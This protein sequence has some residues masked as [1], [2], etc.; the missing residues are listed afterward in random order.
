MNCHGKHSSI[1]RSCPKRKQKV[2]DHLETKQQEAKQEQQQ[3]SST[4][5]NN[6]LTD[7]NFPSLKRENNPSNQQIS[8]EPLQGFW[9][10]NTINQQQHNHNTQHQPNNQ[11]SHEWEIKLSIAGRYDIKRRPGNIP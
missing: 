10:N 4:V 2:D 3:Q 1:L 7:N 11:Q 9:S 6:P 8:N 5:N